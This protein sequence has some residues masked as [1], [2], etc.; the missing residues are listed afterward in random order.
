MKIGLVALSITNQTGFTIQDDVN[1]D[2]GYLVLTDLDGKSEVHI[3]F[4]DE[5]DERFLE[6]LAELIGTR[7]RNRTACL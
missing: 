7:Q 2:D 1:N 4:D 6:A 5:G 3:Y